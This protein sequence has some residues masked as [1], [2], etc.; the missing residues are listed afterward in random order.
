MSRRYRAVLILLLIFVGVAF[1]TADSATQQAPAATRKP[2]ANKSKSGEMIFRANCGRC[3]NAPEELSPREVRAVLRHMRV[4][5]NL[6]AE[7]ERT[8]LQFMAP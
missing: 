1:A 6:S 4:R 3:H 2:P 7:D 5:A 8:L